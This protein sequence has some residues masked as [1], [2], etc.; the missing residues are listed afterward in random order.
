M[1]CIPGLDPTCNP[2]KDAIVSGVT[3]IFDKVAEIMVETSGW[4]VKTLVTGWIMTPSPIMDNQDVVDNLRRY[5]YWIMTAVAVG[6]LLFA[7]TRMVLEGSGKAGIDAA[8]GLGKLVLVT[9][10][11]VPLTI[12]L[13]EFGDGYARWIITESVGAGLDQRVA[14]FAP[15]AAIPGITQFATIGIAGFLVVVSLIQMLISIGVGG[16]KI[17]LCG[18]APVPAAAAMTGGG[19]AVLTRYLTVL[20]AALL[21]KPAAATIY[22][23]AFWMLGTGQSFETILTGIVV[24][25]GGIFAMPALL[26]LLAPIATQVAGPSG[27]SIAGS[28]ADG[29]GK[30]ASGAVRLQGARSGGGQPTQ[31]TPGGST[32]SGAPPTRPPAAIGPGPGTSGTNGAGPGP[33]PAGP[34]GSTGTAGPAG[35]QGPAGTGAG[36]GGGTGVAAGG[37]AATAGGGAAAGAGAAGGA[38]AAAGPAGAAAAA[39]AAVAKAGPAVVRKVGGIASGATGAGEQ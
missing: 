15:T 18:L 17:F 34:N 8:A 2:I 20:G 31:S 12:G 35:A 38:A 21:Y 7:A 22:A 26:R 11:A 6:S 3:S 28:T 19:K 16:L 13:T 10:L 30:I 33:G 23:G 9:S 14:L 24:I 4:A 25:T 5:T 1:A 29:V 39:G 36:A 27:A 32:G 37:G